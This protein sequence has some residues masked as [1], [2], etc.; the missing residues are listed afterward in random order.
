MS[1]RDR[2]PRA[3][4]RRPPDPSRS[5]LI[6]QYLELEIECLSEGEW[7]TLIAEAEKQQQSGAATFPFSQLFY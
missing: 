6:H 7:Q 3:L 1:W 5:R 4:R 2:L